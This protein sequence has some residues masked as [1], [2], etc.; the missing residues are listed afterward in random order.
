[1]QLGQKRQV[2]LVADGGPTDDDGGKRTC[3]SGMS[4][5]E[6]LFFSGDGAVILAR[7]GFSAVDGEGCCGLLMGA[8]TAVVFFGDFV[9]AAVG[10]DDGA[11]IGTLFRGSTGAVG[12]GAPA[13]GEGLAAAGFAAD[14]G[15]RFDCVDDEADL[16]RAAAT[17]FFTASFSGP[18]T[19]G[20]DFF[21]PSSVTMKVGSPALSCPLLDFL[22]ASL[23]AGLA[24]RGA[25]TLCVSSSSDSVNSDE[26]P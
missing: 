21:S 10:V 25:E 17:G 20:A 8:T 1:M 13:E 19:C 22:G 16:F 26:D 15:A 2:S 23:G 4:S 24:L 18:L 5:P 11:V 6:T 12:L 3:G 7:F 14:T 9:G